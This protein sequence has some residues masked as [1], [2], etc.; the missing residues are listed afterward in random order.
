[1]N[2]ICFTILFVAY[3]CAFSSAQQVPFYNHNIINPFVYNPAMAGY[4]G[5]LNTYVTRGQRFMGY[6]TGAINNMLT[7]EGDFIIPNSG[8]GMILNQSSIG[9]M[10]QVSA[11]LSYSYHLKIN[12][13][14]NLRF[15]LSGGYLDNRINT[16]AIDVSQLDDPFLLGLRPNVGSFDFNL[17]LLYSIKDTRIGISV[18]QLVGNNV[19]FSKENSRGYYS[20]A[21]HFM[22]SAEH[23]FR[24]FADDEIVI[25]PQVLTRFIPGAPIQYDITAHLDYKNLGWLSATYKSDYA[26]QFNLGFHIK[27][28]VH[29]GYSYEYI[30]GSFNN[31]YSGFNHEFLLGYTFKSGKSKEIEVMIPDPK[32]VEENK[33]LN[34][35]LEEKE[36]EINEKDSLFEE[37]VEK[38]VEEELRKRLAEL[39]K[40]R[41]KELDEEPITIEEQADLREADGNYFVELDGTLSPDGYYTVIGV[42]SSA[43]NA[44]SKMD[45]H[46][47]L[48]PDVY[49]VINKSN[50]YRYVIIKYTKDRKEAFDA[51][52]K[53][54]NKT[55]ESVWILRYS[56]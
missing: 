43:E 12:E 18:P 30:V 8:F 32:V 33:R 39:E 37:E 13:T 31:Y 25:K 46:R 53:Y 51:L 26:V 5:D 44:S 56:K 27:E 45:S 10:Q 54:R 35:E 15:G 21:R 47:E 4:S 38:R 3:F 28:D 17:G 40:E 41:E 36:R 23:D 2:K 11:Q 14:Q 19:K 55:G 9:I 6:G 48:F 49:S 7:L 16:A 34:E 50:S 20:L 22:L 42:Y 24:F 29:V 1:M 52:Y